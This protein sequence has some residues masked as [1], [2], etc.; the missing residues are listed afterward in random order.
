MSK[1]S[2]GHDADSCDNIGQAKESGG[3]RKVGRRSRD[4]RKGGERE[5]EEAGE[6]HTKVSQGQPCFNHKCQIKSQSQ[7]RTKQKEMS[8]LGGYMNWEVQFCC[9]TVRCMEGR[10]LEVCL[11]SDWLKPSQISTRKGNIPGFHMATPKFSSPTSPFSLLVL[12]PS[13][14]LFRLEI[15]L[16]Q[17]HILVLLAY[18]YNIPWSPVPSTTW[19]NTSSFVG[20][21]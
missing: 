7:P 18:L 3:S 17:G 11:F 1:A 12:L 4:R 14:R 21:L 15:P 10:E 2:S 13:S 16:G 5:E 9:K 19:P 8:S 6:D 20:S